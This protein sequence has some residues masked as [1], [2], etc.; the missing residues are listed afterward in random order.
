MP[1]DLAVL[2]VEDDFR[3]AQIHEGFV[4]D[5]PGFTVVGT[6]HTAASGLEMV[7]H[8]EPDLVLLD[9]YLP[10]AKGTDVL[11]DLRAMQP[12]DCFVVTAARDI[13]TVKRCL[14][15]GVLH[16]LIKPFRQ[17]D[18]VDRLLEYREWKRSLGSEN[19]LTQADVDRIFY[20]V[21]RHTPALPKGLSEP[22]MELVVA[23]LSDATEPLG[24][25]DVAQVTGVSRVSVRRYLKHLADVGEASVVQDYGGPG[26]PRQRFLL[27]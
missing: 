5:A 17:E 24:A 1:D 15:L 6:A 23:A 11:A 20:G 16:Y 12:V 25:E 8:L 26:R 2:I 7:E 22:T 21:G 9:I 10:D 3:V 4:A 18:L 13:A 14:D 19:D 27:Q